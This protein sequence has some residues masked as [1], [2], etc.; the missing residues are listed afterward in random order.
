MSLSPHSW[1]SPNWG[2]YQQLSGTLYQPHRSPILHCGGG[3]TVTPCKSEHLHP[4]FTSLS[5]DTYWSH[6]KIKTCIANKIKWYIEI[7]M[8]WPLRIFQFHFL[9]FL[10]LT[11]CSRYSNYF[12]WFPG[13]FSLLPLLSYILFF[14][15][16]LH[17]FF[18]T[19]LYS[20]TYFLLYL[21]GSNP[22]PSPFSPW[23]SSL[24]IIFS[25]N[26]SFEGGLSACA[27]YSPCPM[28]CP[29]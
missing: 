20:L 29:W 21:D 11:L 2:I 13:H 16:V 8:V 5:F 14:L 3:V 28:W 1:P 26:L 15:H 6:D 17:T 22:W 25:R 10:L 7:L 27:N 18:F 24:G 23:I 12:Q 4:L 19:C 9:L